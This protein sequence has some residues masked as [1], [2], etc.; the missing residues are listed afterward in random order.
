MLK[1]VLLPALLVGVAITSVLGTAVA[2]L[3]LIAKQCPGVIFRAVLFL[4][5]MLNR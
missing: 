1:S 5:Q 3:F 4:K 2:L